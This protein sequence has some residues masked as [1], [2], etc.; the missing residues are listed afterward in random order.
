MWPPP[1]P[2]PGVTEVL[3]PTSGDGSWARAANVDANYAPSRA[4][5]KRP[6][7][8]ASAAWAQQPRGL[9][10]KPATLAPSLSGSAVA[11]AKAA[12]SAS[13]AAGRDD[14]PHKMSSPQPIGS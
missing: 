1:S 2:S 10:W 5:G 3:V 6:T 8:S 7:P 4:T 12:G 9:I 11:F 14:E 13:I